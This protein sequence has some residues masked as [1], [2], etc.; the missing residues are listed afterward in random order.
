MAMRRL[1][2]AIKLGQQSG[3]QSLG[4]QLC[5]HSPVANQRLMDGEEGE[6]KE[7]RT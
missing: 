2:L 3:G 6:L 1:G 5:V 4:Q 7:G